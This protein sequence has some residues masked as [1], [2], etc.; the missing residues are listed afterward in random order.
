MKRSLA[1]LAL[2]PLLLAAKEGQQCEWPFIAAPAQI[3]QAME[4]DA[5]ASLKINCPAKSRVSAR[6]ALNGQAKPV[7]V[8]VTSDDCAAAAE[9]VKGWIA[10]RPASA[11]LNDAGKGPFDFTMA[12]TF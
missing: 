4:S 9:Y 1:L 3:G 8:S 7:K 10:D 11:F 5:P 2:A 12:M 6:F